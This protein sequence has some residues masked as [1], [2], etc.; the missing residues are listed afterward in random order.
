MSTKKQ[1]QDAGCFSNAV[2]INGECLPFPVSRFI[3]RRS[4]SRAKA[5]FCMA[6]R[7]GTKK[8]LIPFIHRAGDMAEELEILEFLRRETNAIL[9]ADLI[10]GLPG[11]DFTS[12]GT[13]FDRLW[14][15]LSGNKPA[16]P[17]SSASQ[18]GSF[19]E[20]QVGILKCLPGTLIARHNKTHGM[21]YSAEPPYEVIETGAMSAAEL[22]RIKN[23]ARFWEVIVNRNPF[24]ELIPRLL[25]PGE[26]AFDRFMELSDRLLEHFGRNWGI[27]RAELYAKL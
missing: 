27:D 14:K 4:E 16:S 3:G 6:E 2:K 22:G 11:E 17:G 24:P 12:F 23:F 13:G 9:H 7:G 18:S 1:V 10:A 8:G 25:P 20:I 15:V 26:P 21:R 19:F 5:C